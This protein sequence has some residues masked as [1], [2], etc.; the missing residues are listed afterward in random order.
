MRA[1]PIS[2]I[3]EALRFGKEQ[4]YCLFPEIRDS[5]CRAKVK[6]HP[7]TQVMAKDIIAL[8]NQVKDQD[9][10]KLTF[11]RFIEYLE[12]GNRYR[13]EKLFFT[14]KNELHALVMAE[15][16]EGEGTYLSAIEERLWQW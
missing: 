14:S 4:G 16:I 10:P 7:I 15:I 5:N 13:Y 8:A 9:P 6:L 11:E 2:E 3:R 1:I 12:N